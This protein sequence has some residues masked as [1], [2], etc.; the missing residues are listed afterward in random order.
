VRKTYQAK[1]EDRDA[2]PRATI[3]TS[4]STA[5]SSATTKKEQGLCQHEGQLAKAIEHDLF[6]K[7]V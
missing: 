2:H 3:G 5:S 4:S 6:K 7:Y 1:F